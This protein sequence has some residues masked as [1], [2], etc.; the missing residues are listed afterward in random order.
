MLLIYRMFRNINGERVQDP[1]LQQHRQQAHLYNA[2]RACV[3]CGRCAITM[4]LSAF[5]AALSA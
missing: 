5:N 4:A 2:Q 1:L 3:C